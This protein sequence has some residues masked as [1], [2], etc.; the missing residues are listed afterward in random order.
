MRSYPKVNS[1][2]SEKYAAGTLLGAEIRNILH[3]Y[4]LFFT[5]YVY[6]LCS[7]TIANTSHFKFL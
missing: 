2:Q 6:V 5:M 7:T 3:E 4:V 1:S